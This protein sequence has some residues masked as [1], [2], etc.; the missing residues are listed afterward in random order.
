VVRVD[1]SG[2]AIRDALA[3]YGRG[4]DVDRFEAEV[5]AALTAV[6]CDRD[7]SRVDTVLRRWHAIAI[8]AA[9]CTQLSHSA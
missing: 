6:V 9:I 8:L 3:Q 5:R 2:P 7:M 4:E 1:R